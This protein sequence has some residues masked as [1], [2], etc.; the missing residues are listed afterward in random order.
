[1]FYVL[2]PATAVNPHLSPT[3][4]VLKVPSLN[5]LDTRGKRLDHELQ[6]ASFN[7]GSGAGATLVS[8]PSSNSFHAVKAPIMRSSC[9]EGVLSMELSGAPLPPYSIC[10]LAEPVDQ[11]KQT[12]GATETLFGLRIFY[13]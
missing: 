3:T 11:A 4:F 9:T 2:G 1:M 8:P 6:T 12:S 13:Y 10:L 7:T 5:S